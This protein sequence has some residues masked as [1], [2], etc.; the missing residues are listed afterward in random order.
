MFEDVGADDVLVLE[1][2]L[3]E[4]A[5]LLVVLG[6]AVVVAVRVMICVKVKTRVDVPVTCVTSRVVVR[7][8]GT[9][10]VAVIVRV[11]VDV[12]GPEIDVV[13]EVVTHSSP[14][15]QSPSSRSRSSRSRSTTAGATPN[16]LAT[17]TTTVWLT[18]ASLELEWMLAL[19]LEPCC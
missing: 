1:V 19:C 14:S 18:R 12:R 4:L 6:F 7:V 13:D 15:S 9:T 2:A 10:A 3:E 16:G 8:K 11:D 17:R 5:A